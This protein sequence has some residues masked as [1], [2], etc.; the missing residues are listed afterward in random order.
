MAL[1]MVAA[2][3][4][5]RAWFRR[6]ATATIV[7]VAACG[8]GDRAPSSVAVEGVAVAS[9]NFPESRLVAEI[10]AQALEDEG[11]QVRRELD[12]GPRELVMPALR[13]GLVDVVPEYLG[14]AL[15]ATAPLATVDRSDPRAV[16]RGLTAAVAP[17]GL[18]VLPYAR[19]QN[20]NGVVVTR[21][22]ADRLDLAAVSDLGPTASTMTIGGPPECPSRRYCLV[23]LTDAYSLRFP[24]FE[25]FERETF[26]GRALED[27]VIDVGVMF[28]TD[29][30]LAGDELVLLDDDR[31]LQPAEN[32]VPIVR[33]E[34]LD[35]EG[36]PLATALGEVSAHLTTANLRFMN[37]RVT[38]AG[39]DPAAEARGWLVRQ[40]L[41]DR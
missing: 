8:G 16:S 31:G 21:A 41:V 29:G 28:T 27:D 10:Y 40:G 37:W 19:A 18:Q 14:T 12:L 1:T 25:P 24:S 34:V 5:R 9:F 7:A 11:V 4:S 2:A 15:A 30:A 39:N 23:G 36:E 20:Q 26:V 33:S 6:V 13:Q 17:W 32:L 22:T 3:T 35:R 38:V